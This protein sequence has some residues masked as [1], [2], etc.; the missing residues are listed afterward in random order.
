MTTKKTSKRYRRD[1]KQILKEIPLKILKSTK[2]PLL[3]EER[4]RNY[5]LTF[6]QFTFVLL[7]VVNKPRLRLTLWHLLWRGICIHRLRFRSLFSRTGLLSRLVGSEIRLAVMSRSNVTDR[8]AISSWTC[9]G[10]KL[11]WDLLTRRAVLFQSDVRQI[12][13]PGV[14]ESKIA[15]GCAFISVRKKK[16]KNSGYA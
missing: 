3:P 4:I 11:P 6:W 16:T 1:H 2:H 13:F 8:R 14:R 7:C 10:E 5:K 12:F 15:P 9:F